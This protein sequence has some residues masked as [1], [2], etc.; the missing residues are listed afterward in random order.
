MEHRITDE[1]VVNEYPK[2]LLLRELLDLPQQHL[3]G[4]KRILFWQPTLSQMERSAGFTSQIHLFHGFITPQIR[5]GAALGILSK[6]Q[7]EFDRM[8]CVLM[9]TMIGYEVG[10]EAILEKYIPHITKAL[11]TKGHLAVSPINTAIAEDWVGSLLKQGVTWKHN[12]RGVVG[13]NIIDFI[14]SLT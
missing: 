3:A 5:E 13:Q 14:N 11:A 9:P 12:K 2:S 7:T 4:R 8:Y 6:F 1:N 10:N